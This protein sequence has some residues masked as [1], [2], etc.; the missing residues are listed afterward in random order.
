MYAVGISYFLRS[1]I[2]NIRSYQKN[3][4]G[5]SV[6]KK[7]AILLLLISALLY[8]CTEKRT[9]L[10]YQS[11]IDSVTLKT[12]SPSKATLLIC[13]SQG[14][15]TILEPSRLEGISFTLSNGAQGVTIDD[16]TVPMT[17]EQLYV[18]G[19]WLN[20]FEL[21]EASLVSLTTVKSGDN[22]LTKAKFHYEDTEFCILYAENGSPFSLEIT[23]SNVKLSAEV[24]DIKTKA[25][26]DIKKE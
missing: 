13:P 10:Q 22:K 24:A 17:S 4:S 1:C 16:L 11:D 9:L 14:T 26:S 6:L 8:S 15:I 19:L 7:I 2:Y 25:A 23:S 21:S 18:I 5:E 12:T 3:Q 20:A